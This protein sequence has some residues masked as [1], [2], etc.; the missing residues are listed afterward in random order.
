MLNTADMGFNKEQLLVVD[1]NSG[2]VRRG[3]ETIKTE[4]AKIPAVKSVSVTS[5]VPGEWK[6]IPKVKAKMQGSNDEENDMIL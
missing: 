1:I 6:I 4:Y 2:A 5:R 3:A